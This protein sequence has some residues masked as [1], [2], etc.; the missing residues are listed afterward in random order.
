MSIFYHIMGGALARYQRSSLSSFVLG[1]TFPQASVN[2]GVDPSITL[3]PYTGTS[4][5][6]T[7]NVT[8]PT[9]FT[10]I[11]FG[12]THIKRNTTGLRFINCKFTNSVNGGNIIDLTSAGHT[13]TYLYR[14]TIDNVAQW[15]PNC[16]GLVG[17]GFVA[18]RCVIKNTVDAVDPYVPSSLPDGAINASLKG[19]VL[20]PMSWFWA[21]TTGVVH[22]SDQKTHNDAVQ[23]QGGRGLNIEGCYVIGQYSTTIGTGTPNSGNDTSGIG[24]SA[25]PNTQATGVSQRFSIIEGGGTYSAG[26]P[27]AFLGGSVSGLMFTPIGRGNVPA[28]T[29]RNNWGTGGSFWLNAGATAIV[30]DSSL[31]YTFGEVSGN[32]VDNNQRDAGWALGIRTGVT[33]NVFNNIWT[34]GSGTIPRKNA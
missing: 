14:C 33:A 24:A 6:G 17:S 27:G 34:D 21:P 4:A 16:S 2:A 10:N 20:G 12:T 26:Q 1:S 13:D 11:D 30:N 3:T 29:I 28:C 5:G 18:E 23:W 9:T 19:C 8:T 32:R 31:T 22:P 15:S 25:S 7:L